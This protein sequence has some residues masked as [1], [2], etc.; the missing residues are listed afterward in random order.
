MIEQNSPF[1]QTKNLKIRK[2]F[3]NIEGNSEE[4]EN[5]TNLLAIS[6]LLCVFWVRSQSSFLGWR[7]QVTRS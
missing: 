1:S 2:L 3:K 7:L 6:L 5:A 4:H